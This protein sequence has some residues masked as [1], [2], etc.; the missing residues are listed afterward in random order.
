MRIDKTVYRACVL[1]ELSLKDS[2]TPKNTLLVFSSLDLYALFKITFKLSDTLF[3]QT[4][5]VLKAWQVLKPGYGETVFNKPKYI[6]LCKEFPDEHKLV[7]EEI[8]EK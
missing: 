1:I 2:Y 4:L 5:K 7:L 8:G 3:Y 6:M